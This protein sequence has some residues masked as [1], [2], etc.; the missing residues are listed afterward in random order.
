MTRCPRCQTEVP[1]NCKPVCVVCAEGKT[2]NDLKPCPFCGSPAK[3][4]ESEGPLV[5][6]CELCPAMMTH[7]GSSA[8]LIEMWNARTAPNPASLRALAD[9]FDDPANPSVTAKIKTTSRDGNLFTLG[10]LLRCGADELER[11]PR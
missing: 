11:T 9:W 3:I 10:Y 8:A 5:V 1:E 2:M 6:Q 7:D 4:Y